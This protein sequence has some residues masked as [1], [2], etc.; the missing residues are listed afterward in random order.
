MKAVWMT[1]LTLAT[2][3]SFAQ[4]DALNPQ[5]FITESCSSCHDSSVYTRDNRRVRSLGQLHSQVRRCDQNLGTGLFDDEIKIVADY[6]NQQ[7]YRF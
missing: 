6:L 2:A 1:L 4:N 5:T 7:Y 3:P